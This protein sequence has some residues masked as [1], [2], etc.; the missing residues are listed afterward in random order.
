MTRNADAGSVAA[1]RPTGGGQI[2]GAIK[3]V[4]Q[5]FAITGP[6]VLLESHP[7]IVPMRPIVEASRIV[8][9]RLAADEA[10][11]RWI[12]RRLRCLYA[13]IASL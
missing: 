6:G 8:A 12:S 1:R 2:D 4:A 11:D 9:T 10:E 7:G 5:S 3:Y 13:W